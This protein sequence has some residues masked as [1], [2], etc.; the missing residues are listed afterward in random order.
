MAISASN[1]MNLSTSNIYRAFATPFANTSDISRGAFRTPYNTALAPSNTAYGT[2]AN[3]AVGGPTFLSSSNV[4]EAATLSSTNGINSTQST[5]NI[6]EEGQALQDALSLISEQAQGSNTPQAFEGLNAA[7]PT[8]NSSQIQNARLNNPTQ[9]ANVDNPIKTGINPAI[10]EPNI[11]LTGTSAKVNTENAINFAAVNAN[12]NVKLSDQGSQSIQSLQSFAL[13]NN[14]HTRMDGKIF[15]PATMNSEQAMSKAMSVGN[16]VRFDKIPADFRELLF[17]GGGG[18]GAVFQQQPQKQN[19]GQ[20][21]AKK[22]PL[23]I[24]G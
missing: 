3:P 14:I 23:N 12:Y 19:Q 24:L 9:S 17:S 6:L 10:S 21:E 15:I 18:G 4:L 7:P 20:Q 11:S 13:A 22:H 16:P 8:V 1:I 5:Q 2:N